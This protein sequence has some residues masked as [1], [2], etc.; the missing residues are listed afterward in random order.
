MRMPAS[1]HDDRARG[2]SLLMSD[3]VTRPLAQGPSLRGALPSLII[4]GLCPFLTYELLTLYVPGMSQVVALGLG[5][6]FPAAN[7]IVSIMRRRHLDIIGAV[8]LIGITVNIGL[9]VVGGDP[10]LLLI[11]ES[12]V[13]GALGIVCLLSLLWPRPFMF[14]IGRQFSA[15]QDQARIEEFNGLWQYPGAR[16][17]FR[18][19]TVVWAVV[20]I[21]EFGLRVVMVWTLSIPEVLAISPFVFNGIMLG[22]I[23]WTIAYVRRRR[24]RSRSASRG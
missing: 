10:K 17:T 14:Y 21:A 18:V 19:L 5:A 20:W 15:G 8:V 4:D 12:F 22:L 24:E 16:S 23:A 3:A 2:K 1:T 9:T 7:G 6:M 11:R 13:T